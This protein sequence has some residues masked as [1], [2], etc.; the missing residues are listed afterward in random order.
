MQKV[1][2]QCGTVD[3]PASKTPGSILI[4]IILWLCFL[5][6]GLIYSIWRHTRRHDVCRACGSAELVP[7]NTPLGRQMVASLG[8]DIANQPPT[9]AE[10]L[11]RKLGSVFAKKR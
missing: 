6:P 11:G 5:V 8:V 7:V 2:K 9:G 4:E 1:C 10:A 3:S